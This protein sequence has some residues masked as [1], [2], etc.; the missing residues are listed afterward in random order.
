MTAQR[1]YNLPLEN[2][3]QFPIKRATNDSESTVQQ[4]YLE[5][6]IVIN[7]TNLITIRLIN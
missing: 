6:S 3:V 2:V 7:V 1:A 4:S 5:K